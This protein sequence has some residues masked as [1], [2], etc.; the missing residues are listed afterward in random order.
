MHCFKAL[1]F[2]TDFGGYNLVTVPNND[3]TCGKMMLFV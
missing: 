1:K 3:C 2:N